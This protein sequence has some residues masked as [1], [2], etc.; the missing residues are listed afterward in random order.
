MRGG[1]VGP[2]RYEITRYNVLAEGKGEKDGEDENNGT[3]RAQRAERSGSRLAVGPVGPVR[4]FVRDQPGPLGR[5]RR[6]SV[7]LRKSAA[8]NGSWGQ[9]DRCKLLRY[10]ATLLSSRDISLRYVTYT[11]IY[12]SV[13]V[14]YIYIAKI[15]R[16]VREIS[17][18]RCLLYSGE[19]QR[20]VRMDIFCKYEKQNTKLVVKQ[21]YT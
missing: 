19:N 4:P 6:R 9:I 18:I 5:S 8:E 12:H 15:P 20:Y 11:M 10:S 3:A 13:V 7:L 1:S 21:I 2:N 17:R 14:V 16:S